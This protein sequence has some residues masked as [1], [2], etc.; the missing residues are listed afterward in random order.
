MTENNHKSKL[1]SITEFLKKNKT[2]KY[3]LAIIVAIIISLL[4]FGNIFEEQSQTTYD[5]NI[6]YVENLEKRLSDTLSSVEN[7]GKVK[8]VLTVES[9]MESVLATKITSSESGGIVERKEEPITVNGKTVI[10]KE[11]YP[12]ITG[13]LIVSEGANNISVKSKLLQATMSLL[14]IDADRIEILTM[15]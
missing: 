15:K 7:A 12:K 5:E 1:S 11:N 8:V 9:G 14:D 10:I 4:L 13:V 2:I 3:V 6:L